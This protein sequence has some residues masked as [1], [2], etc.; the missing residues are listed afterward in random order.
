MVRI[1][2]L[3]LYN[4]LPSPQIPPSHLLSKLT[5]LTC[6][7]SFS[8]QRQ[9]IGHKCPDGVGK[10]GL[11]TEHLQAKVHQSKAVESFQMGQGYQDGKRVH[12]IDPVPVPVSTHAGSRTSIRFVGVLFWRG[13]VHEFMQLEIQVEWT[14][15]SPATRHRSQLLPDFLPMP[16]KELSHSELPKRCQSLHMEP[17]K[18]KYIWPASKRKHM[19]EQSRGPLQMEGFQGTVCRTLNCLASFD[20]CI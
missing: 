6:A 4:D 12:C 2:L 16:D 11:I 19:C 15:E 18:P 17:G 1:V 14:H 5:D 9:S 13:A 3:L 8:F 10:R 20:T 7:I